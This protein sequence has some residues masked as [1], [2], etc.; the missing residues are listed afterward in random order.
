MVHGPQGIR[1][2]PYIC[3]GLC[4]WY[5]K[6]DLLW[7]SGRSKCLLTQN[8][9]AKPW[10]HPPECP[11]EDAQTPNPQ[12]PASPP[13]PFHFPKPAL[14]SCTPTQARVST[15]NS[16]FIATHTPRFLSNPVH[17]S[18]RSKSG[19]GECQE[20]V[21]GLLGERGLSSKPTTPQFS[22]SGASP[23]SRDLFVH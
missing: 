19:L 12:S 11:T 16:S 7:L 1:G 18:S 13:L 6:S 22:L 5:T 23:K 4:N 3:L 21:G 20:G 9:F 15:V 8:L 14:P 10:G 2:I 17:G